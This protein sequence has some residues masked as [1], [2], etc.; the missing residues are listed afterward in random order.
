MN[1][2]LWR[3]LKAPGPVPVYSGWRLETL[4]LLH[5][6]GM[7]E[8]QKP[9]IMT[10]GSGN[11]SNVPRQVSYSTGF[12]SSVLQGEEANLTEVPEE[13]YDFARPSASTG[14]HF[15]L[16]TGHMTRPLTFLQSFLCPRV[17]FIPW[18]VQRE[19][20]W[21]SIFR[22]SGNTKTRLSRILRPIYVRA[23]Q[24]STILE[25]GQQVTWWMKM[26]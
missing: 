6:S 16:L 3:G 26:L 17:I 2:L 14:L 12:V 10:H 7:S 22:N 23:I 24:C 1:G 19:R 15:C 8:D 18:W 25:T 11:K 4:Q 20:L 9:S 5:E 13:Y 21:T